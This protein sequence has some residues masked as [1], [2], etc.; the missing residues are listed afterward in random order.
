MDLLRADVHRPGVRLR[1][2]QRLRWRS[3]PLLRPATASVYKSLGQYAADFGGM[4]ALMFL[5]TLPILIFYL[6]LQKHFVKGLTGG[7]TKG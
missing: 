5:A 4:F 2:R 6:L 7:A 1:R 3:S